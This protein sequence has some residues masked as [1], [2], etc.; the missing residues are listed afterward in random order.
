MSLTLFLVSFFDTVQAESGWH[1]GRYDLRR[2]DY[3]RLTP[4][5]FHVLVGH[6]IP[7]DFDTEAISR[8]C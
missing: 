2:Y 8:L 6:D 3:V 7:P 5:H 1:L 4:Y